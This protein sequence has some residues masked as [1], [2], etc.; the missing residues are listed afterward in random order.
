MIASFLVRYLYFLLF[1]FFFYKKKKKKKKKTVDVELNLKIKINNYV[2][3][4]ISNLIKLKYKIIIIIQ[5]AF[6]REEQKGGGR[7]DGKK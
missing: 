5:F 2:E 1:N 7:E 4:L 6:G 3:F